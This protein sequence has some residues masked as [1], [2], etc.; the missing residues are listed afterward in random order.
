[1]AWL[2]DDDLRRF[3][4]DGY[5]VVRNVVPDAL[6]DLADAEID[7]LIDTTP[8]HED[9]RGPAR[10]AVRQPLGVAAS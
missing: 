6:L 8:P 2:T 3:A 9:D 1:V 4:A 7:D 10:F 5:L